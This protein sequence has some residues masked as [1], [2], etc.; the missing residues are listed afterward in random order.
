MPK[1]Y[2]KYVTKTLGDMLD[3]CLE[4]NPKDQ[5]QLFEEVALI[6]DVA[7]QAVAL[8]SAAKELAD[9]HPGDAK[10][11]DLLMQA[12]EVMKMQISEVVKTCEAASRVA[13]AASDK[14][15]IHQLHFFV[16]QV[17]RCAYE[18]FGNDPRAE[19]FRQRMLTQVRLPVDAGSTGTCVTPDMDVMGMDGSVPKFEIVDEI[20]LDEQ[21]HA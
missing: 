9:A 6:R 12:G 3:Q 8:Y 14:V 11:R 1:F 13:N 19:D 15:S 18:A 10:K 7:G 5:L 17:T 21:K 2:G 20:V 4:Q 16:E